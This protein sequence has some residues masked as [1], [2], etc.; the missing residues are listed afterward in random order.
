M[1][2]RIRAGMRV[3]DEANGKPYDEASERICRNLL[4]RCRGAGPSLR[5]DAPPAPDMPLQRVDH[6]LMGTTGKVFAIEGRLDDPA[7]RRASVSVAEA[8][9]V[10][11]DES[12]RRLAAVSTVRGREQGLDPGQQHAAVLRPAP[13]SAGMAG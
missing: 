11:V 1:Y 3:I 9:L 2:E 13:P 12:D 5:A 10:T 8:A 6:V 7:H 4:A